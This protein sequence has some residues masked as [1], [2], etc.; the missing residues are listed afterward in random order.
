[1]PRGSEE[2]E[3]LGVRD[4]ILGQERAGTQEGATVSRWGSE[5]GLR[6]SGPQDR[7]DVPKFK[8]SGLLRRALGRHG[9]SRR[10]VGPDFRSRVS[11]TP[12]EAQGAGGGW[13]TSG[14]QRAG[15]VSRGDSY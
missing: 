7:G 14:G 13:D 3:D 6:D 15:P 2:A 4:R 8:T 10:R 5:G 1:M 12:E 9:D 11:E